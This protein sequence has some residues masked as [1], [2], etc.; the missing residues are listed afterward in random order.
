MKISILPN[1]EKLDGGPKEFYK[2]FSNYLVEKGMFEKD[3]N[4][5]DVLLIIIRLKESKIKK[6]KKNNPKIK[7]IQRLDGLYNKNE[8]GYKGMLVNSLIKKTFDISDGVVFQSFYSK[9]LFEKT[10]G[11]INKEYE[12]IYNGVDLKGFFPRN[13]RKKTINLITTGIFRNSQM[14]VP[15][16]DLYEKIKSEKNYKMEIIGRFKSKKTINKKNDI[17]IHKVKKRVEDMQRKHS[18]NFIFT[19]YLDNKIL[20]DHLRN[21]D[22]YIFSLL[23][24]ACPNSVIEALA[25]G[26]PILGYKDSSLNELIGDAGILVE[27]KEKNIENSNDLFD[28][29]KKIEKNL[30]KFKSCAIKRSE[31][32]FSINK[33]GEEYINFFIYLCKNED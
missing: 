10:F 9:D 17:K 14:I 12:V 5:S 25:S 3:P 18:E 13:I 7:I 4:K 28:A 24:S 31:E 20:A 26:L 6:I 22:I 23:K 29:L 8:H 33:M 30:E 2:K 21:S 16:L 1:K 27:C 19:N 32:M 15:I 11:C